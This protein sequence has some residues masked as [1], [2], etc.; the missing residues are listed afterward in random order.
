VVQNKT[1]SH[2]H[3]VEQREVTGGK[4]P[5]RE[6]KIEALTDFSRDFAEICRRCDPDGG[7]TA[8][9]LTGALTAEC[10]TCQIRVSGAELLAIAASDDANASPKIKRIRLGYCAR[11]TCESLA[12]RIHFG[13]LPGFA[14]QAMYALAET[15][16][17]HR[18]ELVAAE[19]AAK[20]ARKR[21]SHRRYLAKVALA[22]GAVLILIIIRQWYVGGRI[23]LI[24]E[25]EKFR[26][27]PLPAENQE[28]ARD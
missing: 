27:T 13:D 7:K 28:E 25:P 5:V 4:P 3:R 18:H 24:R 14:L 21:Q 11:E 10:T 2:Q 17:T 26:V 12:Y 6:V 23:R 9:A 20:S 15:A 16:N 8:E 1:A 22:L 19:A